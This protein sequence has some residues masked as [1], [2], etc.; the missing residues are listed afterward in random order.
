[1]SRPS[2]IKAKLQYTQRYTMQHIP[3]WAKVKCSNGRFYAPQ[4]RSDLEWYENTLF[5]GESKLAEKD[6]CYTRGQTWPMGQW[7]DS[8]YTVSI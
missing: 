5:H 4:F 1:M 6:S 8:P 2:F 7:L 3:Q